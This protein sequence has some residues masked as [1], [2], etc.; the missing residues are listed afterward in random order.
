MAIQP[1]QKTYMRRF[2]PARRGQCIDIRPACLSCGSRALR[3]AATIYSRGTTEAVRIKG[4]IFRHGFQ[5]TVRQNLMAKE[6]RPPAR[7]PWFLTFFVLALCLGLYG[8]GQVMPKISFQ[9]ETA[10]YYLCW[11]ITVLVLV[12][13]VNNW[14]VYP[15]KLD[16]WSRTRLC[17]ACG[18]VNIL[19]MAANWAEVGEK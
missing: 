5:R 1:T 10:A 9:V 2:D 18:I 6:F 16:V 14:F 4:W 17:E 7:V 19:T 12:T 8:V 3:P 15:R 11:L 13:V